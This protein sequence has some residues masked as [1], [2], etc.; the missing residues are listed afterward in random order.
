VDAADNQ[1]LHQVTISAS[2][3]AY[4]SY[5]EDVETLSQ[6]HPLALYRRLAERSLMRQ[7]PAHELKLWTDCMDKW[8]EEQAAREKAEVRP[9]SPSPRRTNP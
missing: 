3:F 5:A 8:G 2:P 6:I 7:A 4:S 9:L 1:L